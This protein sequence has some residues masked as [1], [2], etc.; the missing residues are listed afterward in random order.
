M[1]NEELSLVRKAAAGDDRAFEEIMKRYE[2]LVFNVAMRSV[3]SPTEAEY[4]SQDAFYKA[5][6][7]LGSFRGDCSL[8]T[9]LCRITMNCAVDYIRTMHRHD[10]ASLT[11]EDEDGEVHEMEVPDTDTSRMPEENAIRDEQIRA[12]REA[13]ASLPE[14]QKQIVTMRDMTGM[15]YKDISDALSLEMGTVKSRLNR[16]RAAVKKYL[17]ER[18]LFP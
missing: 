5:W 15:S 17:T 12:V 14:E 6:R 2:K 11:V 18:N 4:V 7:S 16:A 3:S 8:S 1:E 13:I 10:A 9:W